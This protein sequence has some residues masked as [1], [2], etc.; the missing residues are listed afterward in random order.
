MADIQD[1][2]LEAFSEKGMYVI[3]AEIGNETRSR[4][5]DALSSAFETVMPEERRRGNRARIIKVLESNLCS[6]FE[7]GAG[8]AAVC[9][10]MRQEVLLRGYAQMEV[11]NGGILRGAIDNV[12]GEIAD[13]F[14]GDDKPST[15]R[16]GWVAQ[17]DL[18]ARRRRGARGDLCETSNEWLGSYMEKE[19]PDVFKSKMQVDYAIAWMCASLGLYESDSN[20]E[21]RSCSYSMGCHGAKGQLHAKGAKGGAAFDHSRRVSQNGGFHGIEEPSFVTVITGGEGVPIH[22]F[23]HSHLFKSIRERYSEK[24]KVLEELDLYSS[25]SATNGTR[26][27]VAFSNP[28][29]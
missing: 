2:L 7:R 13:S 21:G 28:S 9:E 10:S 24:G 19:R 16:D 6:N 22:I 18:R 26:M 1:E 25:M 12:L 29:M 17:T 14:R 3:D 27:M 4:F 11:M 15:A 23:P 8:A 5:R 20:E